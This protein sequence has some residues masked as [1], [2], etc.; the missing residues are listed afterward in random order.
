MQPLVLHPPSLTTAQ[1]GQPRFNSAP[2][3]LPLNRSWSTNARGCSPR[4]SFPCQSMSGSP[5]AE[6]EEPSVTPKESKSA[7]P[8]TSVPVATT[9]A[10]T[11]TITTTAEDVSSS[12]SP[13]TAAA[14]AQPLP[15][16]SEPPAAQIPP[17]Y[18]DQGTQRYATSPRLLAGAAYPLPALEASVSGP[19]TRS[20]TQ[21]ST[22]RTKAHVAS[23][24]VNCKKKHLGCDPARPCR[25]CVL[26]G[27]A[28]STS[29]LPY[30]FD[31]VRLT[32]KVFLRGCDAQEARATTAESG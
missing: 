27:K 14:T 19:A 13:T 10:A 24:C 12:V 26:A 7:Y 17:I 28:V 1:F 23:A 4:A 2:E 21:K 6:E 31:S 9:A 22:R 32:M 25:R 29:P 5:P 18:G 30:T 15:A 11:T 3:R 8:P 16:A 20:L